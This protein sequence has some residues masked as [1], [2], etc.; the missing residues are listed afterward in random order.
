M[1]SKSGSRSWGEE[2]ERH[3]LKH[4]P[5][6]KPSSAALEAS[7]APTTTEDQTKQ[8]V[9]TLAEFAPRYIEGYSRANRE[10]HSTTKSKQCHLR[11]HL[12][13]MF[14]DRRLDQLRQED[15]QRLKGKLA[16]LSAKTVNNVLTTLSTMLKAAVDWDVI[17]E[18]PVRIKQLKVTTPEMDFYDFDEYERIV[19]A[20]KTFDPRIHIMVLLGGDAGLRPGEVRAL[21]WVAIDFRRRLLTVDRAEYDGH[22]GLP[23]HDK[24]RRLPMTKRLAAALH[25]H[26]HLRGPNVLYRDEGTTLTVMVARRWLKKTLKLANLRDRGPHTLR[27][28]FCSHLAMRGAPARAIQELA[29]HSDL[30]TTQRYM[31][32]SPA[33]LERSI[34]LLEDRGSLCDQDTNS[35]G[36]G[37]IVE[38]LG[39]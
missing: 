1:A 35:S 29:G 28:S 18:M 39:L 12:L 6:P 23:K 26:R 5:D 17:P 30:A 22:V 2:R 21:Q 11:V 38:T 3:L 27:H 9:P 24:I 25:A 32:L 20:A 33:A 15:I 4:G 36:F 10:K 14:G 8:E 37:D 19:E 7:P 13:P 16:E 31:H 34:R